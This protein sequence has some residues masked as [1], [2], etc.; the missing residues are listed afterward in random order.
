M[1]IVKKLS[2]NSKEYLNTYYEII[3]QMKNAMQEDINSKSISETYIKQIIPHHEAG[4]KLSENILKY[5][6]NVDVENFAK[7]Y[8]FDQNIEIEKLQNM[9]EECACVCNSERDIKL[10]T[11]KFNE[12]LDMM[13]KKLNMGPATNNIDALYLSSMLIH[14]E[15]AI[16]F[17]KN[18]LSY[19]ICPSLKQLLSD[20]ID[21]RNIY[22]KTIKD[23]L[24]NI[25]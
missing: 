1:F 7:N 18:A 15:G 20:I 17:A 2:D 19:N 13:M 10:Y 3:D 9:L 16:S 22:I 23:V 11:R 25:M 24:K 5:T 21:E 14:S 4:V 12:I 6:T 8:I